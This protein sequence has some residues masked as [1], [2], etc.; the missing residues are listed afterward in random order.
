MSYVSCCKAKNINDLKKTLL[1]SLNLIH[2]NFSKKIKNVVLKPNL[3]YYWD[4]TTGE[5]TDPRIIAS[6]INL[7]REQISSNIKISIIESDASAMKCK[8]SFKI[9]GYEKLAKNLNVELI[10]L[11]KEKSKKVKINVNNKKFVFKIPEIISNSDLKINIPK[12]KYSSPEIKM[13]C[14]LKNIFGCI[15]YPYKY[16][17]HKNI[18]EIIV[19]INKLLKFDLCIVDGYIVSGVRPKILKL[20]MASKDPVAVDAAVAKILGLN[21]NSIEYLM[22]ANKENLGS[23]KYISYGIDLKYFINI[24]PQITANL[25]IINK[26]SNIKNKILNIIW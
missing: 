6:I 19:G 2:F 13:T 8:Y 7:L 3:C 5:T 4:Y 15:P 23:I 16:K 24:Y 26:Y 21:P 17:Y 9:L 1:N 10:N 22:L 20:L 12:I 25:K 14:A 18:S 11:T